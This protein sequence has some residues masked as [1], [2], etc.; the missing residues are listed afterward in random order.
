VVPEESVYEQ[1]RWPSIFNPDHKWTFRKGGA[2]SWS[3]VSLDVIE[4]AKELPNC[5]VIE[6]TVQD[7]GYDHSLRRVPVTLS[8]E[9]LFGHIERQFGVP[10][11]RTRLGAVAQIQVVLRKPQPGCSS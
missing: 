9:R 1:G 10:I 2:P 5:D 6:I 7:H 8:L 4:L 3:P 11:D